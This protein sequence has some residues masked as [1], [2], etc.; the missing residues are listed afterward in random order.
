M[1]PS[2]DLELAQRNEDANKL[3]SNYGGPKMYVQNTWWYQVRMLT[4]VVKVR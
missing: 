1:I 2:V 4:C 3:D